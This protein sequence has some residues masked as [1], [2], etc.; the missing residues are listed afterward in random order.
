M[1]FIFSNTVI[2]M[3]GVGHADFVAKP[4]HV[5]VV[6]L[7]TT[8]LACLVVCCCNRALPYMTQIGI[9]FILAGFFATVVVW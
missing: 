4:W 5:F 1:N 2:Q 3:Y 8:W 9:F 6:Y 7:I